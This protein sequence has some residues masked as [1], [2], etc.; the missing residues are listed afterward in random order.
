[1]APARA[2]RRSGENSVSAASAASSSR[3][4]AVVVD[5]VFGVVGQRGRCAPRDGVDAPCRPCTMKALPPATFTSSASSACT[6]GHERR[7]RRWPR[8]SFS[9][10]M[11]SSL[12]PAAM[13]SACSGVSAQRR[14]RSS[15]P[16]SDSSAGKDKGLRARPFQPTRIGWPLL[17]SSAATLHLGLV[18]LALVL[19][20]VGAPRLG[21]DR[22]RR[23]PHHVELAVG[24]DLADEHRLVQV[25]VL[26]VH[27][28]R[29]AARRLEGLAGHRG[30]HLVGVGALGL[31]DRLR[32]HV[33]A[34]VGGFHRVVG[35][36]LVLVAGDALGLGVV[37][38]LLD[39]LGRWPGS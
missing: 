26:L 13:R 31:L 20:D 14:R 2:R 38:P 36:R 4:H 27:L 7:R 33:D 37:A 8:A 1:M 5:D 15:R 10:A 35:Q 30:D 9:A 12:S 21:L 6:K 25:V 3:A 18:L 22:A 28:R 19:G 34:D 17:T 16:T 39:E 11:R 29:D 23:L 24:L 32:P